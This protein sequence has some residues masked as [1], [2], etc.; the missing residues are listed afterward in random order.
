MGV[1]A[2]AV[3]HCSDSGLRQRLSEEPIGED[4]GEQL[5]R[6]KEHVERGDLPPVLVSLTFLG[7]GEDYASLYTGVRFDGL[8]RDPVFA[9]MLAHRI[10]ELLPAGAHTDSSMLFYPDV[11]EPS[12]TSFAALLRELEGASIA[13]PTAAVSSEARRQWQSAQDAMVA[14]ALDKNPPRTS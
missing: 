4:F 11:A 10:V 6:L 7:M 1:D 14:E 5:Q 12:A 8:G 9:Q 13:A 3:I 2:V